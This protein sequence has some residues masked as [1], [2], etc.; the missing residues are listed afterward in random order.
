MRLNKDD[1]ILLKLLPEEPSSKCFEYVSERNLLKG[2]ALIYRAA[3][4][5]S[6]ITGQKEKMV[7]IKCTCC[8]QEGYQ[9]YMPAP[10]CGW[11]RTAFGFWNSCTNDLDFSYNDTLCPFCGAQ[12]EARYIGSFKQNF[13]LSECWPMEILNLNGH[14]TLICWYFRKMA[15]REGETWI[16]TNP[17]EAYMVDGKKMIKFRGFTRNMGGSY[18]WHNWERRCKSD[19]T[20]GLQTEYVPFDEEL[21]K[22]TNAKHCK[23]D[24]YMKEA[25]R[26]FPV[27]YIKEFLKHP[28][29]ENLILQGFADFVTDYLRSDIKGTI[30]FK[31]TKPNEMLMLDKE[32]YKAFKANSVSFDELNFRNTA[33]KKGFKICVNDI[34]K[35]YSDSYC[36]LEILNYTKKID[37]CLKYV[38]RQKNV[39][40]H[41]LKDYYYIAEKLKLD[42]SNPQVLFPKNLKKAHDNAVKLNIAR[43]SEETQAK[44]EKRFTELKKFSYKSEKLG[45]LIVPCKSQAELIEE[46]K[47]LHHC[48][49]TY[50]DRVARG[51]TA[52]FFIRKISEPDTPFYTLEFDEKNLLVRQNRGNRNSDRTKEV[53][54]FEKH[55]LSIIKQREKRN[56]NAKC[57]R[58]KQSIVAIGA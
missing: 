16:F 27:T 14:L 17:C 58:T 24:K 31:R 30:D 47:A 25:E 40:L 33:L 26:P 48:V 53:E 2:D 34:Q 35:Y 43:M 55:W 19:D 50:A 38:N 36:I 5:I 51:N 28:N 11:P 22:D 4:P 29:I 23:L 13:V 45:L 57:V 8:G 9:E 42:L 7:H 6:P 12:A 46:G 44:F 3:W 10:D 56:K 52:I 32:E 20:N 49:A 18:S 39:R 1:D 41:E 15:N 37:E 21:L 54:F